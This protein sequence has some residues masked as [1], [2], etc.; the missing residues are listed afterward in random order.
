MLRACRTFP[1]R[2]E[3]VGQARR[4]LC[5]VMPEDCEEV[6]ESLALMLSELATNAVQHAATEFEVAVELIEGGR[7]VRVSVTDTAEGFPTPDA[8]P[9]DAPR[10]RGLHIVS[11]LADTWGV[12]VQR[13]PA[14][15]TVWFSAALPALPELPTLPTLPVHLPVTVPT[16][17]EARTL[18]DAETDTLESLLRPAPSSATDEWPALAMCSVLNEL[19]DAVFA[20]DELGQIRYVNEAA[21]KLVGCPSGSLV[22]R[23]ALDIVAVSMA[24][25][26]VDGFKG[27]VRTRAPELLGRRLP[28]VVKRAD[29]SEIE[30]ELVLSMFEHESAGPVLVGICRPHDDK[31]LQ[32][33]SRLTSELLEIMQDAPLDDPPAER[34][35]STLGRRLGWDMTALWTVTPRHDL[36]CHDSWV[37]DSDL[38]PDTG[39]G[40]ADGGGADVQS[41]HC[42]SEQLARLVI[43]E[44]RP[45]WITDVTKDARCAVD[46]LAPR[47]LQ[48]VYAFPVLYRGACVGVVE[49]LSRQQ[50]PRDR[51]VVDLMNAVAGH[52]GELLHA[53]ASQAER[54]TLVEELLE[55]RRRSE[56]LLLA[57]Q[58]LSEFV[59]YG[60]MVERLAR[61]AVP[62]LADLCLIDLE[63]DDKQ[64]RRMAAWHADPAKR[65]L[66]EELKS[67]YAPLASGNDPIMQVMRTGHS[68]WSADM[69]DEFLQE[70]CRDTRHY[71]ILKELGYSSYMTVPL[72]TREGE[73]IGTVSLVSCGSGRRFSEKDLDLA[74]QLAKQVGSVVSRARAYDRERR[75][76]HELQRNLLPDAIPAVVGW[77]L[78]ARYRPA[79]IG[80]EV[81]GDWYDVVPITNDLVALVVGDVEG[82]DL[83][84]AKTMSHLRRTLGMLLLEERSPGKALERLNQFCLLGAEQRLATALVGVLDRSTGVISFSSAGH[85]PPVHIRA[86][87]QATELLVPPAPPLGVQPCRYKDHTFLLDDGCL[88]MFTDG[89]IERRGIHFDDRLAALESSLG[90]A[91]ADDPGVVAD[92]VIDAMTSDG[93]SADDIV[94]LTARRREAEKTAVLS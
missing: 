24:E 58:V 45:L 84:A 11:S 56:F 6:A 42:G 54:E 82:H 26:L 62:V 43:E 35:L 14:A 66:A 52:L 12:D 4:F 38:E 7:S 47:G 41:T 2:P 3:S 74:E 32:R 59:D 40:D 29:G 87:G 72:R 57:A 73:V 18:L 81:G 23:S 61:V 65:P 70:A 10:G 27:F 33:W 50:R 91:P 94:V 76:S 34:L 67:W 25:P 15:K 80:H 85:P 5:Q 60:E 53:S 28:M 48:S 8:P 63:D 55:A 19:R 78:A 13:D 79:S 89:L 90:S 17:W 31:K 37:K 75:I 9:A 93:R 22:G 86:H 51:S 1:G 64:M 92:F 69:P 49:L 88:V 44:G 36:V 30:T 83:S 20:T 68:M 71:S 46:A 21:E 77:E 39:D 16:H